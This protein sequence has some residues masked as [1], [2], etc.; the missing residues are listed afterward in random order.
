MSYRTNLSILERDLREHR[1]IVLFLGAGVNSS[2]ECHLKWTD[3]INPLL[4]AAL[5]KMAA[6][7]NFSRNQ[8]RELLDLFDIRQ[9]P[10]FAKES[11]HTALHNGITYEYSAPIKAMLIKKFLKNQYLPSLQEIIYSQ[12]NRTILRKCFERDYTLAPDET[13]KRSGSFHTLY[14][15]ARLILLN[16]NVKS[17]ITYNYDNFLTWAINILQSDLKRYFSHEDA[18]HIFER[19]KHMKSNR[20]KIQDISG[21]SRPELLDSGT[22]F[23]YHPHGYIPSPAEQERLDSSQIILSMDEYYENTTNIHTW[24]NDTQVHC[25]SHYTCLFIGSSISDLT[26]QRMLHYAQNNGNKKFL[27]YIGAFPTVI[28]KETP[29][30]NEAQIAL[31]AV[32]AKYFE[33]CGLLPI[34]CPEGF[35]ELFA[36]I[37]RIIE[38]NKQ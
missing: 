10:D 26:T 23:V 22:L 25:L 28:K 30:G 21:P 36:D 14:T 9:M 35:G 31:S 18:L 11:G 2:K 37:N 4:K 12:C 13:Y 5:F 3:I 15:L 20:L 27:Y 19:L 34:M 24:D 1:Q 38:R 29:L 17:V 32:K 7:F 8:L 6:D 33:A 16:S